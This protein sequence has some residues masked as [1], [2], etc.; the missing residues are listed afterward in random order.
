MK[1]TIDKS[2]S[3]KLIKEYISNRITIIRTE[4]NKN[5]KYI[6]CHCDSRINELIRL[7]PE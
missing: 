1:M 6:G 2:I 7:Y 5:H 3:V 4:C